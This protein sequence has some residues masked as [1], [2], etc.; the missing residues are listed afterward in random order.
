MVV[1]ANVHGSFPF[2]VF[3]L[4]VATFED[5]VASRQVGRTLAAT[6]LALA[7]S[8][9]TPYGPSV[10]SYVVELSTNP[11]IRNLVD[12]WQPP[13]PTSPVG[14]LFALSVVLAA[15]VVWRN[16]RSLPWP[17]LVE[18]GVFLVLAASSTRALVWWGMVLPATFARLPWA[19]REGA[20]PRN[21][22]N[23]VLACTFA[24]IPIFAAFRWL[25][26]A[27]EA[28]PPDLVSFAPAALTSELR[29][30]LQPGEPFKN[31]QAWGS[32]FELSLPGHPLF[33]DSRFELMPVESLRA[34][35]RI[36]T[37]EPGWERDLDALAVRVLVVDREREPRLAD[38][39]ASSS[40]W[41]LVF[42]DEEGLIFVRDDRP[43]AVPL[44]PC[45]RDPE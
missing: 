22:A 25:P 39:M 44:A 36:A 7:A 28:P 45:G 42:E 41:R 27:R 18:L 14:V 37:A 4:L 5:R 13:W 30:T 11:V 38:A 9:L 35:H 40:D 17:T 43:P 29:S 23:W 8:A 33:V 10:W 2:G 12:E 26:Y 16:R 3:V 19:R 24:A 32:W 34:N 6:L 1:W 31:P 21:R 20:D 15:L